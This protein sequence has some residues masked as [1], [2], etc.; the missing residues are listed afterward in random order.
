[1]LAGDNATNINSLLE[2]F[3]GE[4]AFNTKNLVAENVENENDL[5]KLFGLDTGSVEV[6]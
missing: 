2:A 3:I 5:Y 4:G 6:G 1:L